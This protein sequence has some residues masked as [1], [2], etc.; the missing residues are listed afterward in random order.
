VAS[1]PRHSGFQ[2]TKA[3]HREW[4]CPEVLTVDHRGSGFRCLIAQGQGCK[5]RD[6]ARP[7]LPIREEEIAEKTVGKELSRELEEP[8][9]LRAELLKVLVRETGPSRAGRHQVVSEQELKSLCLG[10][11]EK[12]T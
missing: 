3:R 1:A 7:D 10:S 4:R 11:R 2:N 8:L 9:T 5:P 12:K 6:I